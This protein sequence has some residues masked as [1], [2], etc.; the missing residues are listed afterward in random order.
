MVPSLLGH[1]ERVPIPFR[2]WLCSLVPARR[3]VGPKHQK[4]GIRFRTRL[5]ARTSAVLDQLAL[6]F[7]ISSRIS[8][9]RSTGTVIA[10]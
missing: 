6:R 9:T 3:L 10:V 2:R 7:A 4:S 5:P 8:G 1:A